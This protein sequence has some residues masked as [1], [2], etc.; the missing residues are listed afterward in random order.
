MW[1]CS[2]I[3]SHVWRFTYEIPCLFNIKVSAPVLLCDSS[4]WKWPE[5]TD[6]PQRDSPGTSRFR[7]FAVNAPIQKVTHV[8]SHLHPRIRRETWGRILQEE[9]PSLTPSFFLRVTQ[10]TVQLRWNPPHETQNAYS[11]SRA[12]FY[13][14]FVCLC[15][16]FFFS[17][18]SRLQNVAAK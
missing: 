4:A 8:R 12:I 13:F 17:I 1:W 15:S 9:L 10:S 11:R 14:F 3:W 18:N 6:V 7:N 5:G 16:P 2:F